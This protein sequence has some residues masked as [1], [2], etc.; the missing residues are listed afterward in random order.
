MILIGCYYLV[1]MN[2]LKLFWEI[3]KLFTLVVQENVALSI[4]SICWN[5]K[6]R[7]NKK[8]AWLSI[9]VSTFAMT[10]VCV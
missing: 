5:N 4:V 10:S 2:L 3:K 8:Y 1:S 6:R 7:E 9:F